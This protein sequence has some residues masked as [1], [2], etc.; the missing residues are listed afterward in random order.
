MGWFSLAATTE[1]FARWTRPQLGAEYSGRGFRGF[2]DFVTRRHLKLAVL[3]TLLVW[4]IGIVATM[5]MAQHDRFSSLRSFYYVEAY[6]NT[7]DS[8]LP[9][10]PSEKLSPEEATDL[11]CALESQECPELAL[12]LVR[13]DPRNA[14]PKPRIHKVWA[15]R[16]ETGGIYLGVWPYEK[17]LIYSISQD[18]A[19]AAIRTTSLTNTVAYQGMTEIHELPEASGARIAAMLTVLFSGLVFFFI[20]P[21]GLVFLRNCF[22]SKMVN[23]PRPD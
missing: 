12:G 7:S 6:L 3:S 17:E 9:D 16:A 11:I 20:G 5:W 21:F 19:E 1:S 23:L 8:N 18:L 4:L 13:S 10:A 22:R 2:I 15:T 14:G